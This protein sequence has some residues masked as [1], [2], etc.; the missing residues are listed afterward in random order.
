MHHWLAGPKGDQLALQPGPLAV[1]IGTNLSFVSQVALVFYENQ[2]DRAGDH[3]YLNCENQA[4]PQCLSFTND[5]IRTRESLCD[6][7]QQAP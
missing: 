3:W 5:R 7:S 2:S 1:I 4:H 6:R